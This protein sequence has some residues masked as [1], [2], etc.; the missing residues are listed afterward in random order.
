[1]Y[2]FTYRYDVDGMRALAVLLV[3]LCHAGLSFA[4]GGYVG[5]DIFFTIS[6]FV[7]TSIIAKQ[8]ES[9]QFSILA[10]YAKR[11]KRLMPSLL[12]VCFFVVLVSVLFATPDRLYANIK[13]IASIFV[14]LSNYYQA[15]NVGYFAAEADEV[16]LL[17]IWSLSVEEQFYLFLPLALYLAIRFFG[18]HVV[19]FMAAVFTASLAW[20]V[21]SL[22]RDVGGAYFSFFGRVYEFVPGVMLA[23]LN[24]HGRLLARKSVVNDMAMFFGLACLAFCV[25]SFD[26]NTPFPGL[27]A[28]L[29]VFSAALCICVAPGSL[30]VKNIFTS[31][32]MTHLGRL[33]Y[34]LYLW[35][36][37]VYFLLRRFDIAIP[38]FVISGFV[39]SYLLAYIT[40]RFVETPLRYM[41][42]PNIRAILVFLGSP[43]LLSMVLLLVAKS[44]NEMSFLYPNQMK[45][46]YDSAKSTVWDLPRAEKCWGK[47]E[48]TDP[49][50]CNVGAPLQQ[51][52]QKGFLW[53]DSHAYQMI[54][55]VDRIG[56]DHGIAVQDATYSTCPPLR[57]MA[58]L[59]GDIALRETDKVCARRNKKIMHYLLSHPEINI[60][61]LSAAWSAYNNVDSNLPGPHGFVR[62]EFAARLAD[63]VG[64]LVKTGKQVVLFNDIPYMPK[65]LVNCD[66]YNNLY[67]PHRK[68][69][70]FSLKESIA[71]YDEFMPV[72][73]DL[74]GK[75]PHVQVL[76]TY[77]ALCK[78]GQCALSLNGVPLYRNGD[79]G[80][81]NLNGSR[82]LYDQYLKRSL[83]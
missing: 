72:L 13:N 29:P 70:S 34:C 83:N 54:E 52:K 30:V 15:N 4:S 1:M 20:A 16:P 27:Y 66:L 50:L 31:R 11:A 48:V 5:V 76:D 2:N 23:L 58:V 18:R 39:V 3:M 74:V 79:Y 32:I 43:L 63:T 82:V 35:H 45:K 25:L 37:P 9:G 51:A 62:D 47:T 40:Y 80:H 65:R 77:H 22:S 36:W 71:G 64:S 33:S 55:F 14:F 10:F 75:F 67:F 56:K 69:C 73:N 24:V 26:K 60:V 61:Y 41:V 28:L 44:T 8:I 21:F 49:Q 68:E 59:P 78:S 19:S 53:G 12:V 17:H 46:L 81:L 57:E 42:M 6:G 38:V 7:V